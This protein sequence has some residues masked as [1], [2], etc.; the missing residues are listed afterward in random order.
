MAEVRSGT[1]YFDPDHHP[2]DT[3]KSFVE[4]VQD[5]ELRYSATYPDPPKV[6]L[7]L[8][9][10]RW[11]LANGNKDLSLEEFDSLVEEWQGIDMVGKFLGIYS[12]RRLYGD[13][14]IADPSDKTRKTATWSHFV[15]K[16]KQYYKPT[17]NLTLKHFQFRSLSQGREET[18]NAFCNRVEKEAKHCQFKCES[19]DCTAEATSVRD[20]IVIGTSNDEIREEALKNFLGIWPIFERRVCAW[21]VWLKGPLRF[22]GR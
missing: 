11:K 19:D 15:S 7:D 22:Q 4:F 5:F 20:Q 9:I 13:W 3:L 8:A 18:F 2:D 17:E 1:L 10:N 6:S 12:S 16:M 14:T 21:K